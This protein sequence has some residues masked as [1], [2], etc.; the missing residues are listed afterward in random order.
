MADEHIVVVDDEPEVRDMIRDYLTGQGYAVSTA[1]GGAAMRA[2]LAERPAHLA[3]LDLRMPGE[4]GLSLARY[5]RNQG[6]IGIIMV[7]ASTEVIDRVVGLEMGAD[8]YLAKPFDPREL[9]ARVRSVLRRVQQSSAEKQQSIATLGHEVRMGRCMLNLESGRLYSITGEDV[10]LT[11]MEYD[12]LK[13]F[14]DR[15]NRILTRDQLLD[16][17]HNRDMEAFDRSI[18]IRIMR[19]RRKIEDDPEHPQVLK[20]IR[21][22]GYMFVTADRAGQRS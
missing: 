18:D 13:A 9:L 3:I 15:P 19:L 7:T 12:L 17:A 5:L 21:G 20:T 4:D 11:A 1:D 16:L 10:P 8:D 14:A 6:P 22:Q 2:I